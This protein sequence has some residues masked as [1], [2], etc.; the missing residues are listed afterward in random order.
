[1]LGVRRRLG[2]RAVERCAQCQIRRKALS[3]N[4][5]LV[6]A[7]RPNLPLP[8][9]R[10][11]FPTGTSK[12]KDYEY[13]INFYG[14]Y[15]SIFDYPKSDQQIGTINDVGGQGCTNVLHGYGKKNFWIV[16]SLTEINE[17]LVPQKPIKTLSIPTADAI[18]LRHE[19]ERRPCSRNLGWAGSGRRRHL[20]ER[21]RLGHLHRHA[22]GREYFDG[23]DNEGISSSTASRA[24]LTSRS[25][26]SRRAARTPKR[27]QRATPWSSPAPSSGT[28]RT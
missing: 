13:I 8:T 20:Q 21:E 24:A 1:M 5:R 7:A 3:V 14:T 11:S 12:A 17:Y 10:R 16:A 15:A 4:G 28:A 19:Y 22:V 23:Y 2:G 6:T 27:S 26:S 9:T 25:S 18:E